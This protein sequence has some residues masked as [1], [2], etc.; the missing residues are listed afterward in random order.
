MVNIL[1]I[2]VVA[3][4]FSSFSKDIFLVLP[5][6]LMLYSV[7]I[8]IVSLYVGKNFELPFKKI[9]SNIEALM[10][11]IDKEKIDSHFRLEEF[12]FLQKFITDAHILKEERDGAKKR[13]HELTAQAAHDIKSPTTA[14]LVLSQ[15]CTEIAEED[16]I[17]LREAAHTIQDIAN[18]LLNQYQIGNGLSHTDDIQSPQPLLISALVLQV[19]SEKRLQYKDSLIKFESYFNQA[20]YFAFVA[21]DQTSFKRMLSNLINNAVEACASKQG[22]ITVLIDVIDEAVIL[23]SRELLRQGAE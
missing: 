11:N 21:G 1:P 9:A 18:N 7:L 20:G 16:R 19:L 3:Y 12:I 8:V 14:L 15:Q 10:L 6:F 5:L 13:L 22:K 4:F 17:A 2:F 23:S